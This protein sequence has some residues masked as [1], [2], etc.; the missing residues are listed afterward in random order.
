MSGNAGGTLGKPEGNDL[1]NHC[2]PNGKQIVVK[3][4]KKTAPTIR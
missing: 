3:N 2:V 4:W 1:A